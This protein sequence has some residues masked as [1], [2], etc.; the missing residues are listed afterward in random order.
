MQVRPAV[1]ILHAALCADPRL[2]FHITGL[3]STILLCSNVVTNK[4][5]PYS[6]VLVCLMNNARPAVSVITMTPINGI[7]LRKKKFS[8][9]TVHGTLYTVFTSATYNYC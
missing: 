9:M 7:V 6:C 2:L 5:R 3:H 4:H 1:R 8:T